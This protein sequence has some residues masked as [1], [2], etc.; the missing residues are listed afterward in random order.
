MEYNDKYFAERVNKRAMIMWLII[1]IVLSVA[2]A[3]EIL[4]GLK[5]VQ[6]FIV[7][8]LICWVPFI[9]GLI[10][11]KVKGWHFKRYQDIVGLGF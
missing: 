3:I 10:M 1:S 5:T 4:K 11:L 2:Y 8:E 6:Y 7:M 9:A